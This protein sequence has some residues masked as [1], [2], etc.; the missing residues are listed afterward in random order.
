MATYLMVH[1]GGHGGWCYQPLARLL[2][3]QG[4][5]VYAPTLTGLGERAHLVSPAVNLDMHITDIL[6]VIQFE[7]LHDVILAGH[8]YG[9]LV[10]RGVADKIPDRIAHLVFL[11]AATP[12]NGQSLAD[13][14]GASV[15]GFRASGRVVDGVEMVMFPGDG[16]LKNHG[17]T[18]PAQIAWMAPRLTPHPWACFE[19][20]LHLTNEDALEKIPQ[21]HIICK[22]HLGVHDLT[23]IK[24]AS[25]GRL[26][27][28]DTGHDLM[29]SE[30][31]AVAEMLLSV[32][33]IASVP[34]PP[35]ADRQ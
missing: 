29:I 31:G 4:H 23:A 18:D 9:G 2:R 15:Q 34:P 30:P 27:V 11:D 13:W 14:G 19:Q 26:W 24:A 21:T 12:A 1:G 10:I 32:P 25:D 6:K 3:A 7:D 20:K 16:P 33:G 35:H 22:A 8:S 5:E 28:I 17:V